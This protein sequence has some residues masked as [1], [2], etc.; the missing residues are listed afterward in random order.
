MHHISEPTI[1]RFFPKLVP[2]RLLSSSFIDSSSLAMKRCNTSQGFGA[3]FFQSCVPFLFPFYLFY[4]LSL[5]SL[6]FLNFF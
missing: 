1:R 4:L 3:F 6:S 5:F 2:L